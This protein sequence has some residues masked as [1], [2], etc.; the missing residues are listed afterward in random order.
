MVRA[1]N[2]EIPRGSFC[3]VCGASGSGK[4][5]LLRLINGLVPHFSGGV[6]EG[7]IEVNGL[8]PIQL[9]PAPMSRVVGFVFQDPETQFILDNVEDEIAFNLENAAVPAQQITYRIEETLRGLGIEHLQRRRL[10]S[11]SG[12]EKQ[13]VAI[14]TVL[15]LAPSIL[16]FD[17][18]TSQL[19][20][21]SAEEI[22]TL[23]QTLA[24]QRQMTI[25]VAEHRLDRL[26]HFADRLVYLPACGEPPLVG[27]PQHILPHIEAVPPVVQLGKRLGYRPL[28]LSI[29]EGRQML[30]DLG[31]DQADHRD[32][33]LATDSAS[34]PSLPPLL[35]AE[36]VSVR[37]G[38]TQA[39]SEVSLDLFPAQ[40]T[41]LMGANGAGKTTLLRAILGLVPLQQG[42]IR[43]QSEDITSL[44]TWRR[45][46]VIGYLPQDPNALLFSE[47]VL[48]EC[49]LTL[50]NHALP[51]EQGKVLDLLSQLGLAE[52]V[53][54]YPRELSVGERQRVALGS[55]LITEPRVLL[56]DEP[57]RGL[58]ERA[59]ARLGELLRALK[60]KGMAVLVVT[61]DVEFVLNLADRLCVLKQG[62]VI[63]D[64]MPIE[65]LRK[66]GLPPPQIMQLFPE[67][68]FRNVEEA[69]AAIGEV[70]SHMPDKSDRRAA[71]A[72]HNGDN[73]LCPRESP[74][75]V[76]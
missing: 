51:E 73:K 44:P 41:C 20:G 4:S 5:T 66:T 9:G 43:L 13:K 14:A 11:L 70:L 40:I 24:R 64:G 10:E 46:R 2:F 56:L 54:R 33:L 8:N 36:G 52:L 27:E 30:Q 71:P 57:T 26:L 6:V 31:V 28:P 23:I 55:I 34:L 22:L 16:V 38:K 53:Q 60:T 17:E 21:Q 49:L 25:V 72:C 32:R 1:A 65:V 45:S 50:R 76:R 75:V 42:Q 68:E 63:A 19:D 47:T 37:Y 3:L 61:H 12:G 67:H 62:K 18:P 35:S 58:D 39:L 7:E 48:E 29:S 59:K 15:S 69:L 74:P